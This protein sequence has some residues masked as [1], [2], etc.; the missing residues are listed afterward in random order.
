MSNLAQEDLCEWVDPRQL[1]G[2]SWNTMVLMSRYFVIKS[3]SSNDRKSSQI[4]DEQMN[5]WQDR[6]AACV[7]I[8]VFVVRSFIS[9]E[10]FAVFLVNVHNA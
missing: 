4:M 8:E 2:S 5:R 10:R 6:E 1:L 3:F 9:L 7:M